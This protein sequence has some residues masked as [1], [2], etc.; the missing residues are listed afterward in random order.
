MARGGGP[1][2]RSSDGWVDGSFAFLYPRDNAHC[3]RAVAQYRE[4]L[5]DERSFAEWTLEGV[6]DAIASES[7]VVWVRGVRERYADFDRVDSAIGRP[8]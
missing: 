8:S 2:R 7:D 6:L 4:C 3:A 1:S 5:S